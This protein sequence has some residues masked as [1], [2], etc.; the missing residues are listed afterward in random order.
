MNHML[1]PVVLVG[2]ILAGPASVLA[3]DV[4]GDIN[5]WLAADLVQIAGD[6]CDTFHFGYSYNQPGGN[7]IT[8]WG[9]TIENGMLYV[10]IET[11]YTLSTYGFP[12]D[13]YG[14]R[15]Y[16]W[17][18][19]DVDN[20]QSLD[21]NSMLG[22]DYPEQLMPG[23]DI[24]VQVGDDHSP[25][26]IPRFWYQ[27]VDDIMEN[28]GNF[29]SPPGTWTHSGRVLEFSAALDDDLL[30]E[31][32]SYPDQTPPGPLWNV[33]PAFEG[34]HGG[35]SMHRTPAVVISSG[36]SAPGD[37]GP[38]GD[39]DLVDFAVLAA[40]WLTARGDDNWNATCDIAYPPDDLINLE[41]LAVLAQNWL[42]GKP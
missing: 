36:I 31:L 10:F 5:D 4:D 20:S 40:A 16:F 35:W 1:V 30:T 14:G 32:A 33:A 12:G 2:I 25:P 38:D 18:N 11:E 37:F 19:C 39:V 28:D 21:A 7:V 34:N 42:A 26:Y 6:P 8:R 23:V 15:N 3:F 29:V 17:L 27:G 13:I 41:D 9:A 24:T 22:G